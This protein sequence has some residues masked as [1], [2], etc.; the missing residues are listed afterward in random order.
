[1]LGPEERYRLLE[2]ATEL[3]KLRRFAPLKE[4]LSALSD[5]DLVGEPELGHLYALSLYNC[6]LYKA[7]MEVLERVSEGSPADGKTIQYLRRLV[8]RGNL[9]YEL[10]RLDRAEAA[11]R[12]VMASATSDECAGLGAAATINLAI[13]AWA[14]CRYDESLAYSQRAMA[15]YQKRGDAFHIAGCHHNMAMAF[16]ELGLLN[17][18]M[19][20]F[21]MALN[22]HIENGSE[23]EIA[24]NEFE[25]ALV[26]LLLGDIELAELTVRRSLAR[27]RSTG[28]AG[29]REEGEALRVLGTIL[30]RSDRAVEAMKALKRAR[31]IAV[32]AEVRLLE[33]EVSEELGVLHLR[34]GNWHKG[35]SLCD[36]SA[37]IYVDIG[38]SPR[39]ERLLLRMAKLSAGQ[40]TA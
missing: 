29:G 16:K 33:A 26:I 38:A 39:A 10:G 25:R 8:L 40:P 6:T 34:G 36:N 23:R 13:I 12:E 20:Q 7:S 17:A 1:V 27:I 9:E 15:T 30:A 37:R 5:D 22:G 31:T 4:K 24:Y 18:S 2:E 19:S 35:F 21:E 32:R 11:F 3:A 28:A 14:K